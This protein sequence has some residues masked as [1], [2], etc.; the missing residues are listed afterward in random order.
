MDW[1]SEIENTLDLSSE[2]RSA[3]D[4]TIASYFSDAAGSSNCNE[5]DLNVGQKTTA[6]S[7]PRSEP[8]PFSHIY[9]MIHMQCSTHDKTQQQEFSGVISRQFT[10]ESA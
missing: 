9:Y 2:G 3:F 8:P 5:F 10:W 1:V 4:D 6:S 7:C